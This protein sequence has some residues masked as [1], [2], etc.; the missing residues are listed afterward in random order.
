MTSLLLIAVIGQ[1]C[2]QQQVAYSPVQY[3]QTYV[4]PSYAQVE[5][6]IF[7]AVE[8][9]VT[10][11]AGLVGTQQR[12]AERQQ[13]VQ[14]IQSTTDQ[15][16]DQ[17]TRLVT[18]LQRRLETQ[19]NEPPIPS[20]PAAASSFDQ[21]PRPVIPSPATPLSEAAPPP[22]TV[23]QASSSVVADGSRIGP[24]LAILSAKCA[25]CHTG[26]A[27][28]GGGHQLF[29]VDG[30]FSV[31]DRDLLDRIESAIATGSMPKGRQ[32]QLT[33]REYVSIRDFL[34]ERAS[35]LALDTNG[36]RKKR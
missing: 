3:A 28:K 30:S 9:P 2:V 36:S 7:V 23:A 26:A 34:T 10:Y 18:D 5:K 16:I 33:L 15:K 13:Q 24:G 27:T 32:Q 20:K 4:Q 1:S 17:L 11:Y 31:G 21:L 29:A 8:D 25:G 19:Q 35:G 14:Q 12:L 6:T 22:P